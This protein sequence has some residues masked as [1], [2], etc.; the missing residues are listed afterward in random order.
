MELRG[1]G[2]RLLVEPADDTEAPALLV[3]VANEDQGQAA[4]VLERDDVLQL[5]H[6]LGDWLLS[7]QVPAPAEEQERP[8]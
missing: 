2:V 7:T 5:F 3:E 1:E 6:Q 4:L 8:A